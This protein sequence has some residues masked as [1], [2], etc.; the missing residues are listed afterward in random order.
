MTN[1]VSDKKTGILTALLVALAFAAVV[2]VNA[3]ANILPLN[4]VGTGTLSDEIPNLFV[5]AGLTFAVW[6]LIYLLLTLY[7][8]AVLV[9]AFRSR[10]EAWQ[11]ADGLLFVAN[12]A[13]NV[14][15]I[16]S[17]H[18]RQIP[19]S[20]VLML[21]ILGT[22]IA[23][24]ERNFRKFG[25]GGSMSA[26]PEIGRLTRFALTAP[27]NVY[28][29]WISVATIAN[30]T[31]LLVTLGWDGFG[32]DPRIWTLVVIVA[33]LF[34]AMGLLFRRDAVAAP[35]VIVWAYIGIVLKRTSVDAD[36]SRI[37]WISA[38]VAAALIAADV[39]I[40]TARRLRTRKA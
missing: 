19:L 14:G 5:P 30:V 7:A 29:G 3:L 21:V 37:V 18:W 26:S 40:R 38:A 4:N 1:R 36:T 10:S 39:L 8:A 25:R 17:W 27:I 31:A 35:M 33:G 34:V 15:W 24:Q 16:F 11:V 6:G 28:L 32:I 20:M 13:A 12:A 2:T 23:M 22:L 9:Q